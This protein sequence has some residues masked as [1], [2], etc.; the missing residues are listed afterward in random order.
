MAKRLRMGLRWLALMPTGIRSKLLWAFV[1]MSVIPVVMLVLVAAWF[2]FP[3]VREFYQLDR[4]FPLIANPAAANWW[5][6][7]LIVLTVLISLLGS[8]YL[9]VR[10]IEPV[11]D[12]SHEAAQLARGDSMAELPV[13][14]DDEL[15]DLTRALN[16]LTVRI[17][18]NM[19]ELK[20]FGERATQM[21]VEIQQRLVM[22]SGLLQIGELIS[23]P[24]E[25]GL[26]L[27]LI[28]ERLGS[29]DSQ[30]FSFLCLQPVDDLPVAQHR[31]QGIDAR[32]LKSIVF[33]SGH[34]LVDAAHPPAVA[35]RAAWEALDRPNLIIQPL[36]VRN[37][38]VGILGVGNHRAGHQWSSELVDLIAVFAKQT[39]LALENELLLRKNKAL[40]VH[41]E[42]T[43]AYNEAHIRQRLGEEI[44][45]AVMYQRP[46]AVAVFAIQGLAG[47]RA[48]HGQ[49]EAD[50]A[51]KQVVAL[52]QESITDI[53]RVGRFSGNE[54]AV[55]LPERN[56]RQAVGIMEEICRRATLALAN[57]PDAR[58]HLTIL[59]EV[60]ENPLDGATAE[61]LLTKVS[62]ALQGALVR[63]ATEAHN[64]KGGA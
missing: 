43:G 8:V 36:F 61:E 4:W 10:I 48:R 54:I 50:R 62:A 57:A 46:C 47:Y 49:P 37:H 6:F 24:A 45:R 21:N 22:F 25:L 35:A 12:L 56:K 52:I 5:L 18:G 53:D 58:E 7:S 16:Q 20:Q 9:A 27:D 41:D 29:I 14:H 64:R 42:L 60:A 30:G 40:A 44:K 17:R 23:Q 33:E 2:A 59:G 51:L 28:V 38:S 26:I 3:A 34:A 31:A 55:L 11:I 15:G 32:Y 63:T 39:S 13:T 1:L 19:G